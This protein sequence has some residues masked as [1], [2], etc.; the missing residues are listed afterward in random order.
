MQVT[1]PPNVAPS[2]NT[3]GLSWAP[4]TAGSDPEWVRVSFP[5]PMFASVIEIFETS[6]APFV[7]R[8]D[9]LDSK[10]QRT[11]VF[12]GPDSTPCG[13]ALV[14][15]LP[16]AIQV[17]QVEIHTATTAWEEIDAVKMVGLPAVP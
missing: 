12:S 10:G 1:G 7:T 14:V 16:A 17:A 4:S 2:C 9:L 15:R 11:T 6:G 5:I 3:A 8:V 13:S